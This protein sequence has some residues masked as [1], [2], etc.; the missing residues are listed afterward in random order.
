VLDASGE[1]VDSLVVA[2]AFEDGDP[3]IVGGALGAKEAKA[4]A[5]E[6]DHV[7]MLNEAGCGSVA[8]A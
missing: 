3:G 6:S 1:G 8:S 2:L 4:A 7:T 5:D